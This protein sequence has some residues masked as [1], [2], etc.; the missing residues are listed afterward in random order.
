MCEDDTI[1]NMADVHMCLT[2][3]GKNG[4]ITST[5]CDY[6]PGIQANQKWSLTKIQDFNDKTG[7]KQILHQIVSQETKQCLNGQGK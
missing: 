1:R 2:T 4:G 6:V 7:Q 5:P 3:N